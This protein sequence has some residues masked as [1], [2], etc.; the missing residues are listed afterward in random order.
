MGLAVA[1]A[2]V[3]IAAIV[4]LVLYLRDD[5]SEPGTIEDTTPEET[6][7]SPTAD[8]ETTESP[9]IEDAVGLCLPYE[10]QI[11]GYSFDLSTPCDGEE[12]FWEVTAASDDVGASVDGEGVLAD[13]Q[14]A[15]D[16]CGEDYGGFQLGEP[17]KDWY[18]TYDESTSNVEELYCVE[19]LGNPDAEGRMPVTPDTG[20]CFDDSDTWWSV[21]CDSELALYEV[22]DT[23]TVDPPVEMSNEEANEQSAP[24]SGGEFFWQ[25]MNV[26]GL[27]SAILCGDE[28]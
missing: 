16:V 23:V 11:S 3:L 22:V 19:A 24:C 10:P 13:V 27:T 18:F 6:T 17:W 28:L 9:S 2:V 15:Y 4:L 1:G 5:E 26:E 7:E 21:P 12:A 8:E 20:D 14:A 25:I